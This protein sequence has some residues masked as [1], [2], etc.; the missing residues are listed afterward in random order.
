LTDRGR[1][2]DHGLGN[3]TDLKFYSEERLDQHNKIKIKRFNVEE[4]K[5]R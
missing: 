1:N 3:D 2:I 4:D 5:I